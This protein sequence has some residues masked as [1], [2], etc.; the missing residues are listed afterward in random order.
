MIRINRLTDYGIVLLTHVASQ[1]IEKTH[2]ARDLASETHL[3]APVVSK[4]LKHLARTGLLVSQRGVKG[5]YRLSRN[6]KD[7]SV[8]EVIRSLE[9]PIA[10]TDCTID[11]VSGMIGPCGNS[12]VCSVHGNWQKINQ[13][14]EEALAGI[15]LVEMIGPARGCAVKIDFGD[16]GN[17]AGGVGPS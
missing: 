3:P 13:V 7:I 1:P 15:S 5:G 2:N 6:P 10:I 14:V 16:I 8:A 9:G 11:S 4:I 17:E 12:S